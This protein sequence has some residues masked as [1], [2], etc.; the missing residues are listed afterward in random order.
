M[1][2]VFIPFDGWSPG[3]GYFGDGWAQATNLYP[4]FSDWRPWRKFVTAGAPVADGPMVGGHTHTWNSGVST[5]FYSPDDVTL[6]TGSV[7]NPAKLY[8][9]SAG[10]F[11]NV[12]R[13]ANYGPNFGGWRFAQVG[14][15]VW[16]TNWLDVPQRRTNNAGLFANGIT[17]AFVPQPRFLVTIREHL[18]GANLSNAG[19][20]QDEFVW[21]DADN[22]V[23]FDPPTGTSTSL[24]G[25]KRL[26]S[27]PGQITGLVGGQYGLAF[28]QSGI[29]YLEYTGT[30][31]VFRPEILTPRVG[32]AYP[33]SIINSRFG[34]A[35]LGADGF[36][37]MAGLQEPVKI[38]PPGVDQF[39][40]E[41]GFSAYPFA[42]LNVHYP[43]QEDAQAEGFQHPTLP[44][45]GWAFSLA[46]GLPS[47]ALLYNPITQQWAQVDLG[48]AGQT[49][50]VP[51]FLQLPHSATNL[52]GTLAAVAY[53][54]GL[55]SRFAPLASSGVAANL[56]A[57]S[58]VSR[59]RVANFE[60][61]GQLRQSQVKAALPIF[62]QV[63]PFNATVAAPSVLVERALDPFQTSVTPETAVP[64][65][66]NIAGWYPFQSAGR[67]FRITVQCGLEDFA[68]FHGVW[69]DQE[70]LA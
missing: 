8:V 33:S 57:P 47:I 4:H 54:S 66:R 29:F 27:I 60:T 20:F 30:T 32:T 63:S 42:P 41:S 17:S 5:G 16:A 46:W 2:V 24:A 43:W 7:G 48:V 61:G 38:S 58:I 3:G 44:L 34:V 64:A 15:D 26:T 39:L 45:I 69:I 59:Y 40:L 28:K 11:G 35:F 53:D 36:Y 21:S 50:T 65:N 9:V 13:A 23:N 56:F 19:R 67:L 62:S 52:Y 68:H 14:N 12:S 6:F 70:L 51:T 31:Q 55:Q 10:G 49:A 37:M 1:P 18:V 25:S 22:A